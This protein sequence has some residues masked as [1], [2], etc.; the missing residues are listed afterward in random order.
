MTK[1]TRDTTF[2]MRLRLTEGGNTET[3]NYVRER[4]VLREWWWWWWWRGDGDGDCP[5]QLQYGSVL[6]TEIT[7]REGSEQSRTQ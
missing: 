6:F 5:P 7:R 4:E 2:S 3:Y 1:N